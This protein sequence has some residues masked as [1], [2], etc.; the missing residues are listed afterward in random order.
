ML[1]SHQ[2][3]LQVHPRYPCRAPEP[4]PGQ[5]NIRGQAGHCHGQGHRG[6]YRGRWPG[7]H[8]Q[9]L[10][11]PQDA[12]E[13][14]HASHRGTV[15][16]AGA[17]HGPPD[18]RHQRTVQWRGLLR[19]LPRSTSRYLPPPPAVLARCSAP[20]ILPWR[21]P[22]PLSAH[23]QTDWKISRLGG[24]ITSAPV[25][26]QLE[27]ASQVFASVC[28]LQTLPQSQTQFYCAVKVIS[29]PN[30][31]NCNQGTPTYAVSCPSKF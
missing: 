24:H 25:S 31:E 12:A 23:P 18:V 5:H 22:A 11:E 4:Q 17:R 19:Y 15:C 27:T 30:S 6:C 28:Y 21:P 26:R 20:P 8:R 14:H 9:T 13:G 16:A 3:Q 29:L 10:H 2:A 1:Q 7:R